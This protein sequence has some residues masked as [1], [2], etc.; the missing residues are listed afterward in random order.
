MMVIEMENKK[1]LAVGT[2]QLYAALKDAIGDFQKV[3]T[4]MSE[5]YLGKGEVVKTFKPVN[6]GFVDMTPLGKRKATVINTA[7][8]DSVYDSGLDTR[9]ATII[10][11][12]GKA[13]IV[14]GI[15]DEKFLVGTDAKV[16]DYAALMK[17]Y[18]SDKELKKL[19][20]K[21][22]VTQYHAV[23]IGTVLAEAHQKAETSDDI[24]NIGFNAITGNFDTCFRITKDFVEES[25]T[26]QDYDTIQS[27][28]R[29][30]VDKNKGYL[31]ARKDAGFIKRCHGDAHSGNMF[32]D[33]AGKV[34]L[35]DGIGFNDEFS[36]SDVVADLAFAYMDAVA[37][38]RKDLAE[39]MK[40]TYVKKTGD[41][42]GVEKLLDFYVSYRAFVRG[43]VTTMGALNK[44]G[45]E[46]LE[47]LREADKYF[48]ISKEYGLKAA[49]KSN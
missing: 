1:D 34:R 17:R 2:E 39:T 45:L 28:Y 48:E 19:Y 9:T 36:F 6:L 10:C 23:Q 43:E 18:D 24:A 25:I 4:H 15:I 5:I 3:E 37:L 13:R 49:G 35:F 40:D 8:T 38:G 46:Q 12:N 47:T 27:A 31:E 21:G 30:F 22:L 11:T 42:E 7:I 26:P 44:S 41:S 14:D 16:S 32:I 20:E 33:E 29:E